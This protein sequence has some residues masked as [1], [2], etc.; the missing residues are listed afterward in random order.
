MNKGTNHWASRWDFW[1]GQR[2]RESR[3][4]FWTGI[5]RGQNVATSVSQ[6]IWQICQ[7]LLQKDLDL[8]WLTRLTF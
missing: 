3:R 4:A 2:K 8:I 7:D 6:L 1:V 5:E